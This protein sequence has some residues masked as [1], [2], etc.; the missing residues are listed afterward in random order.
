[1]T[2]S[3]S[4]TLPEHEAALPLVSVGEQSGLLQD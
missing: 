4:Q 3:A 2:A 1:M